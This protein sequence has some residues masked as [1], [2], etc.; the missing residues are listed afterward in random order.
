MSA[1]GWGLDWAA[2]ACGEDEPA[3][4]PGPA[5]FLA[6]GGL[7]V[8]AEPEH[9]ANHWQEWQVAAARGGFTG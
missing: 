8:S 2:G 5:E 4:F 6:V 9:L 7:G 3:V 1:A